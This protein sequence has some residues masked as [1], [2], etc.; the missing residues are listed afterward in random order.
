MGLEQNIGIRPFLPAMVG[1][2]FAVCGGAIGLSVAGELVRLDWVPYTGVGQI[3]LTLVLL[4]AVASGV[5]GFVSA[6]ESLQKHRSLAIP[7]RRLALLALFACGGLL[8]KASSVLVAS[9]S[10]A[11]SSLMGRDYRVVEVAALSLALGFV[12]SGVVYGTLAVRLRV[13]RSGRGN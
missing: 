13:G 2:L 9:G 1:I 3:F 8:L 4:P 11:P 5:L 10:P 6:R 12:C 7:C